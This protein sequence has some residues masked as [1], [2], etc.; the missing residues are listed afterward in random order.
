MSLIE[1]FA[2]AQ[3]RTRERK[4]AAPQ[5]LRDLR[6]KASKLHPVNLGLQALASMEVL[7]LFHPSVG[8][9][10]QAIKD[11]RARNTDIGEARQEITAAIDAFIETFL[12]K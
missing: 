3:Q 11:F 12:D 7:N 4:Q 6:D 1:R 5:A 9:V 10:K 8:F 2:E